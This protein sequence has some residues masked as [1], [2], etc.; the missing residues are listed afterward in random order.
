V[1]MDSAV[2]DVSITPIAHFITP[3]GMCCDESANP[4]TLIGVDILN[5]R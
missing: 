3:H 2:A 5:T 1:Y 4:V